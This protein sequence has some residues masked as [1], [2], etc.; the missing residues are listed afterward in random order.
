[1]NKRIINVICILL[2]LITLSQTRA[3]YAPYV[4][5]AI[6]ALYCLMRE[7]RA[8][9]ASEAGI[10]QASGHRRAIAL[11]SVVAAFFIT[12]ANY[13]IWLHPILPDIRTPMFVRLVKASYVLIIM[14]GSYCSVRNI[15]TFT[16]SSSYAFGKTSGQEP[17]DDCSKKSTLSC[18]WVPFT[19]I[20]AIYLLIYCL[21]YYPGLL[22]LDSIDQIDQ[23]FTGVYSNHQPFY[24]T[25]LIGLFIRPILAVSG[26]M[27]TAIAFYVTV[28]ILVVAATF[29]FVVRTMADLDLP[30]PAMIVATVWYAIMPF[31]IMFSFTVWKDV[32]FGAFVT[33]LILFFIRL[34]RNIGNRKINIVG[35]SLCGPVICLIR[36]NGLFVYVFVFLA[37]LLLMRKNRKLWIIMG[38]T[39]IS[40]LV[41]KHPVLKASGVVPPD[42]VESLSIPLQ[43]ISRVIADG[44][45]ISDDDM[46]FLDT[47][48]DT[49][50]VADTYNPDISDPV[51]NMIRDKGFEDALT[52][53]M[54]TFLAVY[55]RTFFKNPMTYVVAWVDSTCGYWNS[56]Y[57]YWVWYWDI[58]ANSHGITPVIISPAVR[59]AMDQYLWLYYNNPVLQVTLA[60]GMF[61]WIVLILFA[62]CIFTKNTTGIVAIVPILAI[63]LSLVISAPV[64]AEFRY[65][66]A[67]FCSLPAL[68]ALTTAHRD[69]SVKKA[70][71]ES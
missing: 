34:N 20:S 61:S 44:G 1:M 31:H 53:N 69:E 57:N 64:Y 6:F 9:E 18:F 24:H 71:E 65:M 23:L 41:L 14:A 67:L 5:F 26:N 37:V 45:N 3:L 13:Q 68:F 25:L 8:A 52:D 7:S 19:V 28:Q 55:V 27:N 15:L 51:K 12:I 66:Y 36:S 22:S 50:A 30:R 29:A 40:S 46:A 35:F 43:Q 38:I 10:D 33:L 48:M 47:F 21:S 49:G 39:I 63:I 17:E 16:A 59:T 58:E 56:G 32:Y 62:R 60:T 4:L 70:E 54:G 2:A 11:I 42:T